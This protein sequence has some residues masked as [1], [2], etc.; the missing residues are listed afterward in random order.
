[1]RYLPWLLRRSGLWMAVATLAVALLVLL[2]E[3]VEAGAGETDAMKA[4]DVLA[5]ALLATP[6]RMVRLAPLIAALGAAIFVMGMLRAGEWQGL[7]ALGFGPLRRFAPLLLW[8]GVVGA[9]SFLGSQWVAPQANRALLLRQSSAQEGSL[10]GGSDTWL[11]RGEWIFHLD[12]EPSVSGRPVEAFQVAD[13]LGWRLRTNRLEW[14]GHWVATETSALH[15]NRLRGTEPMTPPAPWYLLPPPTTL[16]RIAGTDDPAYFSRGDLL[17]NPRL[18]FQAERHSRWSRALSCVTAAL[19]GGM[20]PALWGA[21]SWVVAAAALPVVF[22]ELAGTA[23]QVS[24]SQG[25]VPPIVPAL[26]RLL[27]A[28]FFIWVFLRRLRQAGSSG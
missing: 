6:D 10:A 28:L 13:E 19:V 15:P 2:V 3:W 23:L 18:R 24:S 9:L 12:H 14:A 5:M 26:F 16:E 1:M 25:A 22:W 11:Q 8:G 21:G 27:S 7:A 4:L 20:I 17:S